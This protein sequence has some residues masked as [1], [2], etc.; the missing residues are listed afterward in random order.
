MEKK[1]IVK[2]VVIAASVAAIVGIGAVS[3]AAWTGSNTNAA[4]SNQTTG[5]VTLSGFGSN[6]ATTTDTALVPYNQVQGATGKTKVVNVTL[7]GF[8]SEEAKDIKVTK[9]GDLKLYV[10]IDTTATKA[11]G[12]NPSLD[13]W[14]EIGTGYT[15]NG[16]GAGLTATTATVYYAHIILDDSDASHMNTTWGVNFELVEHA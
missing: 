3:F 10:V 9:T 7:P 11:L 8:T 6:A 14:N 13:D 15:Y 1:K 12:N 16:T 4:L 2:P 5:E